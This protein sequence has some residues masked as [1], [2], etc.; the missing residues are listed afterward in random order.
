MSSVPVNPRAKKALKL[1]NVELSPVQTQVGSFI[2][3]SGGTWFWIGQKGTVVMMK[4][5]QSSV[6]RQGQRGK[7]EQEGDGNLWERAKQEQMSLVKLGAEA[8][9]GTE[10]KE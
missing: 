7:A 2:S 9:E 3:V 6:S 1:C 10:K 8:G 5:L 4:A